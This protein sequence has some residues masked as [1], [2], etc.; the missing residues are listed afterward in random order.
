MIKEFIA[1][2]TGENCFCNA[3]Q[4]CPNAY[5]YLVEEMSRTDDQYKSYLEEVLSIRP[6]RMFE[7]LVQILIL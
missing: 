7:V 6:E 5:G 4:Y 2:Y 3:S 1:D